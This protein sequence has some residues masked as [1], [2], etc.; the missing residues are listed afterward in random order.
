MNKETVLE[1]ILR[2]IRGDEEQ[3]KAFYNYIKGEDK[4]VPSALDKIDFDYSWPIRELCF[5]HEDKLRRE[6]K[7]V[8][9][10]E[11]DAQ[12]AVNRLIYGLSEKNPKEIIYLSAFAMNA[13]EV[14]KRAQVSKTFIIKYFTSKLG[15]AV[16]QNKGFQTVEDI[17]LQLE[18][19]NKFY[20]G[21]I[22]EILEQEL[23]DQE[24]HEAV[25]Y[26]LMADELTRKPSE[27]YEAQ[28]GEWMSCLFVSAFGRE[29]VREVYNKYGASPEIQQ[30]LD[31][32]EQRKVAN[33]K[34]LIFYFYNLFTYWTNYLK[35]M[36]RM[37][38]ILLGARFFT[39]HGYY[40]RDE[41]RP[42]EWGELG[43][44]S[45]IYIGFDCV[46]INTGDVDSKKADYACIVDWVCEHRYETM[47][48]IRDGLKEYKVY[49]IN[50][51][52][53]MLNKGILTEEQK[54][55]FLPKAEVLFI[56]C[57]RE[58]FKKKEIELSPE[59]ENAL[60]TLSHSDFDTSKRIVDLS[61]AWSFTEKIYQ[62]M[63]ASI[64]LAPY[65]VGAVNMA[66]LFKRS[67]SIYSSESN[68]LVDRF[69]AYTSLKKEELLDF[70]YTSGF[71]LEV[72]IEL[73]LYQDGMSREHGERGKEIKISQD[74]LRSFLMKHQEELMDVMKAMTYPDRDM[75][76]LLS[77][78]FEEEH[79]FDHDI[80]LQILQLRN[81]DLVLKAEKLL[82]NYE[83]VHV[84]RKLEEIGAGKG[85]VAADAAR[86]IL[87]SWDNGRMVK[88]LENIGDIQHLEALIE[89]KYTKTNERN[90]PYQDKVDYGKVRARDMET[91]V[92]AKTM[93]YFVSEYILL[94]DFYQINVCTKISQLIN[95][96]DLQN[97]LGQLY[98]TWIEDGVDSAYKTLMF[99][100]G[101]MAS[102][103]QLTAL[104]KQI[105]EWSEDGKS[106]LAAFATKCLC[107]NGSKR[108]L[109][110]TD[111]LSKK[112]KNKKIREAALEAMEALCQLKGV[113]REAIQDE[114]VPDFD[115]NQQ[116]ERFFHYGKRQI[117]AVLNHDLSIDLFDETGVALR[118]LPKASE[119]LGDV[120]EDVL[121]AKNELKVIK[122]ELPEVMDLQVRR[123]AKA[124]FAR[125]SWNLDKWKSLFVMNPL[126]KT[127]ATG[128]IW[129]E[130]DS[131]DRLIGTFR[132]MEDGSFNNIQEEEYKL[133]EK[134]HIV[135]LHPGDLS[136]GKV[137]KWE[138]QLS[139]YEITQ[140]IPQLTLD[141]GEIPEALLKSEEL[142][143][144]KDKRVYAG[145][146]K[147]VCT[148]REFS[149][150]F[151]SPG[152]CEG[153]Y[154][155]EE[156]SDIKLI[157]HTEPF[158]ISDYKAVIT[159]TSFTFQK[160]GHDL[161]LKIVPKGL[162][163]LANEIGQQLTQ[164]SV[165]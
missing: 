102:P 51:L 79:G 26:I 113:T 145:A 8:E 59:I 58:Y 47:E 66:R 78:L 75:I 23:F 13:Y 10:I 98:E 101:L 91:F 9:E 87:S 129:E 164:R 154:F 27:A 89:K 39:Q 116:G 40:R 121:A 80:L 20:S 108:A 106:A 103:A 132:Y 17:N 74:L 53:I 142:D 111:T 4:E 84:I 118:N 128:L 33:D 136:K 19:M 38:V 125:R 88:G 11:E 24:C 15:S 159:L 61:S 82:L 35:E 146:L 21:Y 110:W 63:L 124:L 160:E 45:E 144:Y 165:D 36:A 85:K 148:E 143:S 138:V 149:W 6:E 133:Q 49:S 55:E 30:V 104:R 69:L 77:I 81:K 3:K 5:L 147:S 96:Y 7:K 67:V 1:I 54:D 62:C 150:Y 155:E 94:K 32:V 117:K 76:L 18:G 151:R 137:E 86:R 41:E 34:T 127:F 52:A 29:K 37:A 56:E 156:L 22:G 48:I 163:S 83:E 126:M 65:S 161:K 14:F 31:K 123:L 119:K 130:I 25:P 92:S 46:W 158:D 135:L 162:I 97:L 43:V 115:F 131:K 109:L 90:A 2:D 141:R 93:K 44:P 114:I 16:R 100:Y 70:L 12:E 152:Q 105:D 139:D 73:V 122:K 153:I 134:S 28:L 72:V 57:L 68:K 50:L 120:E 99:P 42:K 112:H 140:P 107:I 60:G 71:S 157:L 95:P 64:G